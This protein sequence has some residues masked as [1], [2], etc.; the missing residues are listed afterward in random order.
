MQQAMTGFVTDEHGHWVALLACGHRQHV[1]HD[2]PLMERPWV[3]TEAG[4]RGRIGHTL[5]CRACDHERSER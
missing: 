1:R 2:P 4:R 3:T 5:D